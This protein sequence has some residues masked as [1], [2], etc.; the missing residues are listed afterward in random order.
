[1]FDVYKRVDI[2]VSILVMGDGSDIIG[3][4]RRTTE[5]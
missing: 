2:N 5:L 1:M 3:C 4:D